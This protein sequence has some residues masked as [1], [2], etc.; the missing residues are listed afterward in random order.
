MLRG[1][2]MG[3]A[4]VVPGVS[5]GT[6]ALILG[7]YQRLIAAISHFD[8]PLFA[9]VR[10][11]QW[12]QAVAHID[13]WFLLTLGGGIGLGVVCMSLLSDVLLNNQPARTLTLA[14]FFGAILAS[15]ILVALLIRV[16]TTG[17]LVGYVVLGLLAAAPA[18]WL[19]TLQYDRQATTETSYLYLFLCGALAICAMILPGISGAMILLLLGVYGTLTAIP[20]NLLHGTDVGQSLTTILVF[21]SG[22][23]LG[24]IGFSKVLRRMLA[25]YH[26][27]TMA[28]LCGFM[29]GA[30]PKLW[31]FQEE[32]TPVAEAFKHKQFRLVMPAAFDLHVLSAIA[33]V[34]IA[35]LLV[36]AVDYIAKGPSRRLLLKN[37]PPTTGKNAVD[38]NS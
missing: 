17:Q 21:G 14:V 19:A 6:V 23:A 31:P 5:G 13:L 10:R 25:N 29:L 24:L 35:A 38:C 30:L 12:K 36:L 9:L 28:A 8:L 1:I 26:S 20:S 7:I 18:F 37:K 22:C 11:R 4:D 2:F 16:R 15:A 33:L 3:A 27:P 32:L 34:L